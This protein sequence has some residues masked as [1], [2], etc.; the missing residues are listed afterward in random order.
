MFQLLLSSS[1]QSQGHFRFLATCI[2]LSSRGME[3]HRKLGQLTQTGQKDILYHAI[4]CEKKLGKHEELR[5][6]G[7]G[8]G[9]G[10]L[11]CT[12]LMFLLTFLLFFFFFFSVLVS[13]FHLNPLSSTWLL[14]FPDSHPPPTG[15]SE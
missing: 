6:I 8:A 4:F 12:T 14:L 7:W 2:V 1:V 5:K 9:S 15:M 11:H 3:G 10:Q 13:S